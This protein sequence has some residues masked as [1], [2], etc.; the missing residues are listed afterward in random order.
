ML[1][2]G[3][4]FPRGDENEHCHGHGDVERSGDADTNN[5]TDSQPS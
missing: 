4:A 1:R 2:P 3:L 5:S